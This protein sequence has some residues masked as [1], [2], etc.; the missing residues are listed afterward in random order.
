M[1]IRLSNTFIHLGLKYKTIVMY[2]RAMTS[3]GQR[4]KNAWKN[5]YQLQG[6]E[7]E[8]KQKKK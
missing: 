5:I 2:F 7:K 4:V 6:S 8:K 1:N 3:F